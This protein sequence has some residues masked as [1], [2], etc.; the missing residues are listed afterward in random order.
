MGNRIQFIKESQFRLGFLQCFHCCAQ[1]ETL[2]RS[3]LFLYTVLN[4][5]VTACEGSIITTASKVVGN[6]KEV[7]DESVG[8]GPWSW[9]RLHHQGIFLRIYGPGRISGGALSWARDMAR[10]SSLKSQCLIGFYIL[11]EGCI[12]NHSYC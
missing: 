6:H 10:D 2:C 8:Y 5:P 12:V 11:L 1:P 9:L 4:C 7:R 3:G